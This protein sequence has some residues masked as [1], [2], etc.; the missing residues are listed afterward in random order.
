MVFYVSSVY[1]D[2]FACFQCDFC[3]LSV[4]NGLSAKLYLGRMVFL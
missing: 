2:V 1:G 3:N 4:M